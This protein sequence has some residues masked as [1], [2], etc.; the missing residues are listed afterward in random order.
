MDFA[1]GTCALW[2]VTWKPLYVCVEGRSGLP[3]H[4]LPCMWTWMKGLQ[5]LS[6]IPEVPL[7]SFL[8][9]A[10]YAD[11]SRCCIHKAYQADVS[12]IGL[13]SKTRTASLVAWEQ[14]YLFMKIFIPESLVSSG[15]LF[16]YVT[17]RLTSSSDEIVLVHIAPWGYIIKLPVG[18]PLAHPHCVISLHLDLNPQKFNLLKFRHWHCT[19]MHSESRHHINVKE[20]I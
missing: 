19:G 3:H 11:S 6:Q 8:V 4:L 13:S 1:Y 18:I 16:L 17:D 14:G 12:I 2:Q 5:N 9:L 7:V 10:V 20:N 15:V